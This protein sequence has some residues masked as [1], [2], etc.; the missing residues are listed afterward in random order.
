MFLKASDLP[1]IIPDNDFRYFTM[2]EGIINSVDAKASVDIS[3][4]PKSY[5]TRI[6]PSS[7]D[8]EDINKIIKEIITLHKLLGIH[9]DLSKSIKRSGIIFYE[10]S[11]ND[12]IN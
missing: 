11:L 3:K 2:L 5:I 1:T 6:S 10:I 12:V 4:K 7:P 9:I 8:I